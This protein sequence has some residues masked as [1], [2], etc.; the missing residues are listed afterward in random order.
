MAKANR[1]ARNKGKAQTN[2]GAGNQSTAKDE[3]PAK[4]EKVKVEYGAAYIAEQLGMEPRAV[5]IKLRSKG[6]SAKG[7]RYDFTKEEADKIVA[8]FREAK[9]TKKEKKAEKDEGSA[10]A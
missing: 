10:K 7:S 5:R 8:D 9:K 3:K 4:K 2:Q 1:G 6:L